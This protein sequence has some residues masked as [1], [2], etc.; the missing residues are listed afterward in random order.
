MDLL[1][2]TLIAVVI[3]SSVALMMMKK[4][5]TIIALP[6]MGLSVALISTVGKQQ[7]FG[8]FDTNVIVDGVETVQP[9][10]FSAVVS[11]G[12]TMMASAIAMV[13][14]S[15]AFARML[16]KQKVIEAIIKR[17]GE[18]AGDRPIL[19]AIVFYVISTLVFMGVGGL[20]GVVLVGTIVLPIMLSTGIKPIDAAVIF[21]FGLNSGGIVNPANYAAYVPILSE[22]VGD[23]AV[24]YDMLVQ[25]SYIIFA[26]VFFLPFIYIYFSFRN[27]RGI[28][29]WENVDSDSLEEDNVS[30]L[31]MIAPI[32][33]V[34]LILLGSLT[35]HTI[36][37]EIAMAIGMGYLIVT[38]KTQS[39]M[40]LVSQSFVEGVKDVAGVILLMLGL[41]VLIQ[42]FQY[43]TVQAT[44]SPYIASMIGL[45][46]TPVTYVIGF[47]ILSFMALYRGPLNTFGIGGALPALFSSVGF[48]PLA[49]I[50]ALRATGS[51]QGFGDPTNSHNIWVADFVKVDVNDI[52]K[53]VIWYGFVIAFLVLVT[54]MFIIGIEL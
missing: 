26:I 46:Q 51:M 42:G 34:V 53:K 22:F 41:G 45:L 44:I 1:R 37:A 4:L 39:I 13:I 50:W 16:I 28:S 15:S 9:G 33:P 10:L 17:A 7:L 29:F 54:A 52:L 36:P 40:Q 12:L 32:I 8:L 24:A 3:I 14:F 21:L 5:P 20:G 48:S 25:M 30:F 6:F 11:G 43:P 27:N 47:T 35:G 49:I 38:T 18:F 31:A 19:I 2:I 23:S